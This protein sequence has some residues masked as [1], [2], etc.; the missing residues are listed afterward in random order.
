MPTYITIGN[1]FGEEIFDNS[2]ENKRKS[3][4]LIKEYCE[5][6]VLSKANILQIQ[7]KLD[8]KIQ[9]KK[10]TIIETF[11]VIKN[12]LTSYQ[13]NQLINQFNYEHHYINQYIY[14]E[15]ESKDEKVYIIENGTVQM[16]KNGKTRSK[17]NL[18]FR[19]VEKKKNV[20]IS[21]ISEIAIFGEE[22]LRRDN[23]QYGI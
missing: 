3:T 19:A 6:L 16:Q 7:Q 17:N 8:Q 13:I 5:L 12:I 15:G 2:N 9:K 4:I 14:Q 20:I 10:Q 11:P 23:Y 21:N 1:D 22:I 18:G